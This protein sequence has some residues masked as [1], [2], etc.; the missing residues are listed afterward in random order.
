MQHDLELLVGKKVSFITVTPS[1]QTYPY[2]NQSIR[3][4]FEDGTELTI[5][6]IYDNM[7]DVAR[8]GYTLALVKKG[9][10]K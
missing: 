8:L 6:P 9:E 2:E 3:L 1:S 7:K 4:D 10:I 5:H